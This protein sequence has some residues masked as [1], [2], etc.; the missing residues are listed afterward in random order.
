MS[1][2]KAQ[3]VEVELV[4][5][6]GQC[7]RAPAALDASLELDTIVKTGPVSPDNAD[8]PM[9]LGGA[10][11]ASYAALT[12]AREIGAE[13]TL[14]E[15]DVLMGEGVTSF[16]L[17][18]A[19]PGVLY[20]TDGQIFMAMQKAAENGAMINQANITTTDIQASNGIIHIIDAVI[21]PPEM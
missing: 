19:Y 20:S 13:A 21:T 6:L 8:L 11:D 3:G 18:M 15:M 2:L 5:C 17:F 10:D 14:K 4:S 12:K 7:D 16:K 9:N 1:Y